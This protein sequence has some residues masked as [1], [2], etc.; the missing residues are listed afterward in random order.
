LTQPTTI[1][2]ENISLFDILPGANQVPPTLLLIVASFGD[3]SNRAT[4]NA[5][6]AGSFGEEQTI[7]VVIRIRPK[8]RFNAYLSH[9]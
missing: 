1:T 6:A 9:Y 7:G 4:I 3:R 5:L 2:L 8:S